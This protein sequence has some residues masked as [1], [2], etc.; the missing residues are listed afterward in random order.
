MKKLLCAA[1][2]GLSLVGCADGV[3]DQRVCGSTNGDR[4]LVKNN[5]V[6]RDEIMASFNECMKGNSNRD[7]VYND[8]NE[9]A[10]TC[11]KASIAT[12]GGVDTS[13][14]GLETYWAS[15]EASLKKCGEI[16]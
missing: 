5:Y 12:Y 1:L 8:T 14:G 9:L 11:R 4:Q 2:I 3:Y 16:E 13:K 7:V 6:H 15:I 10:K